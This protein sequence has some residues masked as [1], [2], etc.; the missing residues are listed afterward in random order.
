M[1]KDF[2]LLHLWNI[3]RQLGRL[4]HSANT[5]DDRL[6]TSATVHRVH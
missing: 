6:L 5:A 2:L 1:L 4:R 3:I